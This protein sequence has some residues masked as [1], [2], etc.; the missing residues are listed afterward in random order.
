MKLQ[1]PI[2]FAMLFGL[3][4]GY[5]PWVNEHLHFYFWFIPVSGLMLGAFVGYVQFWICYR[6]NRHIDKVAAVTLALA[7][8][9]AYV[10]VD[11]GI[12]RSTTVPVRNVPGVPDGN[13]ALSELISFGDYMKSRLGSTTLSGRRGNDT[14]VG[15]TGTTIMYFLDLLIA[16][17]AAFGTL[18]GHA[19]IRPFCSHCAR[20]KVRER[21]LLVQL[22]Y[23]EELVKEIYGQI[24][25][26]ME[27]A[28]YAG[29][30]NYLSDLVGKGEAKKG[31]WRIKVDQR[32]CPGC[33]EATLLGTTQ[34]KNKSNEWN[35]VSEL[36]FTFT[37]G[38]GEHQPGAVLAVQGASADR[39][40]RT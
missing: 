30:V 8:T 9:F 36:A 40:S 26:R 32:F 39:A 27:A 22:T 38:K 5:I 12:Y 16:F 21:Q 29:L 37:S 11:V 1:L 7:A 10:A 2:A 4:L 13:H 3:L 34:Q 23:D 19:Q 31:D 18:L 28:D 15:A 17:G 25:E 24:N 33:R 6:L 20:Y 14:E 35:E